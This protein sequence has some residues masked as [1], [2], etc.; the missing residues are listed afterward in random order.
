M[1]RNEA[2]GH[3]S[4]IL[5]MLAILGIHIL[6]IVEKFRTIYKKITDTETNKI[7]RQYFTLFVIPTATIIKGKTFKF[8]TTK[9]FTRL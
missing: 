6:G 8:I 7:V 1:G 2:G 5:L 4:W 3:N 9:S